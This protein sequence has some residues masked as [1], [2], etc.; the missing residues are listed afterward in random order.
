MVSFYLTRIENDISAAKAY[1]SRFVN[2]N[3]VIW[4]WYLWRKTHVPKAQNLR[5]IFSVLLK[6][7]LSG[8]TVAGPTANDSAWSMLSLVK[9]IFSLHTFLS[10][11]LKKPMVRNS[12]A[13]RRYPKPN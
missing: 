6:P 7:M 10:R 4:R 9:A 13:Q 3:I 8:T 2:L 11:S 1:H 5:L 12:P